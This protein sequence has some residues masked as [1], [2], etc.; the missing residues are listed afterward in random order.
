MSS[1]TPSGLIPI[2][3]LSSH[4]D[5][6]V[7]LMGVVTDFQP[8]A[9]S[10]GT[11]WMCNF[12]L[13]DPTVYDDGVK[14]R[15]FRPMETE[16]PK[17]QQNGDVVVL[18]SIKVK[19]W[20]GML[21]G[22]SSH[23]TSWTV[24]SAASIPDKDPSGQLNLNCFGA[25]GSSRPSQEL[26]RYAIELGN[27][28]DRTACDADSPSSHPTSSHMQ[29]L[30][31]RSPNTSTPSS[32]VRK[33]K[34]ALVKDVQVDTFYDL[35]GQVVKLYP[36]NGVVEL[37]ITDY[38]ANSLLFN[39]VWGDDDMDSA[40]RKWPGPYGKMTLTVSLFAP[41]SYYAQN[42]LQENHIVFLRNTRIRWS[43]DGKMEGSLHTDRLYPDRVDVTILQDHCDDRVKDLLRRKLEYTKKFSS[44]SDAFVSLVRGQKRQQGEPKLSKTQARKRRKQQREV[45]ARN[46]K[47]RRC[48]SE[49]EAK[50]NNDP[51]VD[52]LNPHDLT[53]A[54]SP[55]TVQPLRKPTSLNK[56]IRTTKPDIPPRSLSS[57]LSL[58]THA[59]ITPRG[60]PYTL[61]F[62]NINSRAIVHIVDFYPPDIADFAVRRKQASEYDVLSDFSDDSSSSDEDIQSLLPNDSD[63]EDANN[64][65]GCDFNDDQSEDREYT[66]EGASNK[67]EWRF[68]LTVQDASSPC[69][70]P[71]NPTQ[72]QNEQATLYVSDAEA[73]FLLK[74]DAC[75]LRRRPNALATLREKLFLLW[76]DL[77][78]RK[79]KIVEEAKGEEDG[80]KER[81]ERW[82]PGR[83]SIPF[84]CCI[85]E[86]GVRS[87][88]KRRRLEIKEDESGDGGEEGS[89][90]DGNGNGNG[91]GNGW[92][93]GW[94]RRFGL[95]GTTIV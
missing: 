94:E 21:I 75:D 12:R 52:P 19:S 45:E 59:L 33:D 22:I 32:S 83:G 34:L 79:S 65:D 50:E 66:N 49:E 93:K 89:D 61:P 4:V 36:S 40:N 60:T 84:E 87:R 31:A 76:G 20:S 72:T 92:N 8:P 46:K 1:K 16:L 7:D 47:A 17:I 54:T 14:I 38:T 28:R 6:L 51:D 95:F 88:R 74:L 48:S 58:S 85:K 2:S 80:S 25:K 41:H 27:S 81:D 42:N 35:V 78:E 11:D 13:A 18:H 63:E 26:M 9:K 56:N 82:W 70:H 71:S 53:P 62:Q 69:P 91:E 43:R 64:G 39:Y 10:R 5:H 37:Y 30:A 77:E 68:A 29:A 3:F 23:N 86:Y 67:W 90:G 15:F 55:P 24:F 44:E 57:I 73:V